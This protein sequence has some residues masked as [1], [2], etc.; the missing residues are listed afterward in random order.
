MD[1]DSIEYGK[2]LLPQVVDH[3]ARLEPDRVYASITRSSTD[4]SRGFQ[5]ITMLKLA[6]IV[7]SLSWWLENKFGISSKLDTIA[8][9]GPAD[10]RY[11]AIFLA[12]V[13]CRYKV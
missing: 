12:A 7:N 5:D 9:L 11:A 1:G 4:L 8:C 13:K 10:I 3:H 6:A 2:R